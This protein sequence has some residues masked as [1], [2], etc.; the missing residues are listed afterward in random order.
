[1]KQATDEQVKQWKDKYSQELIVWFGDI[2]NGSLT[3]TELAT[4]MNI[5]RA[6]ATKYFY[7][8]YS[9]E[10][11]IG[12]KYE[13]Q[14]GCDGLRS[15]KTVFPDRNATTILNEIK[16]V[17]AEVQRVAAQLTELSGKVDVM[18][19]QTKTTTPVRD[20]YQMTEKDTNKID[21]LVKQLDY[22]SGIMEDTSKGVDRI[23]DHINNRD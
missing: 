15:V 14:P 23:V 21:Q 6:A 17:A 2:L 13:V 7:K 16:R 19:K 11:L 5:S 20:K 3:F 1:M 9:V 8:Y 12:T 22:L 4:R 10:D 18:D